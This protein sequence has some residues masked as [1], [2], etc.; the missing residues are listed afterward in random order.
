MAINPKDFIHP[1]DARALTALE[2]IPG[3]KILLSAYMKVYDERMTEGLLMSSYVRLNEHQLPRI[4]KLFQEVFEVLEIEEGKRPQCFLAMDPQPNAYAT[5]NTKTF[6]VLHSGIVQLL[7]DKELK[8]VIAHE[9]GHILCKHMLYKTLARNIA[10]FGLNM[11]GLELLVKPIIW[12]LL[13]WDRCSEFSC[14]RVSAFV[15]NDA[16]VVRDAM[17]RLSGGPVEL[18]ND[19]NVA[20]YECQVEELYAWLS[21]DKYQALLQLQATLSQGHPF[22]A[23]RSKEVCDW[24]KRA[25]TLLPTGSRRDDLLSLSTL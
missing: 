8:A 18:T 3:L 9:C 5:G 2:A 20:E 13:Y 19:I 11:F 24:F 1:M 12:A 14:D 23:I 22:S 16:D 6:I 21:R 4:Y 15:M 7:N 25:T 17:I 10:T